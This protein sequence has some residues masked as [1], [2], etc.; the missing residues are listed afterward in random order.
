MQL[1]WSYWGFM[2]QKSLLPRVH[3]QSYL[4]KSLLFSPES[5]FKSTLILR[6]RFFK[7]VP[8]KQ[9]R[10]IIIIIIQYTKKKRVVLTVVIHF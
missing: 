2:Y 8:T 9:S 10:V 3:E 1:Y 5:S 6:V 4:V 7:E